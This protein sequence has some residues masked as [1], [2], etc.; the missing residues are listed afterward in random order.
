MG[1]LCCSLKVGL[2]GAAVMCEVLQEV[3]GC[4]GGADGV[5]SKPAAEQVPLQKLKGHL[6]MIGAQG[7]S[8]SLN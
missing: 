7:S 3:L 4:E 8:N 6:Q 1:S 2:G 5:V